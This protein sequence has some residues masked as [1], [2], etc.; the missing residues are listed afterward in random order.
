M[1]KYYTNE[2]VDCGFPCLYDGCPYYKVEHWKCDICGQTD[3]EIEVLEEENIHICKDC[4]NERE[5]EKANIL[6]KIIYSWY[7]QDWLASRNLTQKDVDKET[8]VK[9]GLYKGDMY[10]CFEEFLDNEYTDDDIINYLCEQHNYENLEQLCEKY[11]V[12][13]DFM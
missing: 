13:I 1:S 10:V 8:G 4:Y 11:E 2:C 5:N 3:E 6:I 7:I 12:D 9:K